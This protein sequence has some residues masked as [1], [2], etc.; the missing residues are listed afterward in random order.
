MAIYQYKCPQCGNLDEAMRKVKDADNLFGCSQCG[1]TS[2][3][4]LYPGCAFDF[5]G[6]KHGQA[7]RLPHGAE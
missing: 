3:R 1:A 5:P 6:F 2:T 4:V 7:I